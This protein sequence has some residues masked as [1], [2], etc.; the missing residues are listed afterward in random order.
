MSGR[1]QLLRFKRS[2]CELWEVA[3]KDRGLRRSRS[4]LNLAISSP[5]ESPHPVSCTRCL[6]PTV[7]CDDLNSLSLGGPYTYTGVG[8]SQVDTDG[9]LEDVIVCGG[10]YFGCHFYATRVMWGGDGVEGWM[11]GG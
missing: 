4:L 7:V 8:G 2:I 10:R 11:V 9:A 3:R 5:L 6:I 1:R